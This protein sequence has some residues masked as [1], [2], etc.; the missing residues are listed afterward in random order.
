MF[1]KDNV[2]QQEVDAVNEKVAKCE[3]NQQIVETLKTVKKA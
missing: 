2:T 3:N 1:E